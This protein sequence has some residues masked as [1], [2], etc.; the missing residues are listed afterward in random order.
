MGHCFQFQR[1]PIRERDKYGKST[2][3]K[4]RIQNEGIDLAREKPSRF[5]SGLI[6]LRWPGC[7]CRIR[8]HWQCLD[9]AMW[10]PG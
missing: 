3:E 2:E 1:R 7:G 8:Y 4:N 10:E 5:H 6:L 9:A